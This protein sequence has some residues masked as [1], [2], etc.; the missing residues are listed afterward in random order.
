MLTLAGGDPVPYMVLEWLE[1]KSLDD[2]LVEERAAGVA[3]RSLEA[4]VELLGP[5]AEALSLAHKQGIAHR[6][7]KPANIFVLN[8]GG[9]K[10]LDFGIAKVVQ[11]AQKIGFGK[12][13]GHITS[14]T[15]L[16]GAPEQFNR[17]YGATGPWTD[18]F[19]FA[20]VVSELVTGKESMAGDNLV[21]LAFTATNPASRPSPRTLGAYVTDE[22]E[23]RLSQSPRDPARS[24]LADGR[25]VLVSAPRR[26]D[27]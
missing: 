11:D 19:A 25:Q 9:V 5:V 22:V 24:S 27:R 7:V 3:P 14:F 18:V 23:G 12:T 15:P 13:A 1:G 26:D 2:L 10:L 4:V 20:L 17:A 16:Y 6:D 8:Q 21:Q